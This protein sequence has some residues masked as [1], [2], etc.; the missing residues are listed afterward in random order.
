MNESSHATPPA[1]GPSG[2]ITPN[3]GVTPAERKRA[4]P[5]T[6][7]GIVFIALGLAVFI[8]NDANRAVGLP[9]WV[10]GIIFVG[11]GQEWFTSVNAR[12][13]GK[14]SNDEP[15]DGT[16]PESTA[17]PTSSAP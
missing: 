7:V 12:K 15:G 16:P 17:D 3:G 9:F 1:A 13:R 4:Q 5:W 6:G 10:L 2:G 14:R 11:E 8:V